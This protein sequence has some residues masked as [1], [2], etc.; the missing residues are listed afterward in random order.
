MFIDRSFLGSYFNTES[1][2]YVLNAHTGYMVSNEGIFGR[3]IILG[4]EK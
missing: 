4:G 1:L 2:I 3:S